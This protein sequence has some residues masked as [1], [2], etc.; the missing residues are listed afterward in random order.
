MSDDVFDL[1]GADVNTT[2]EE[3]FYQ[4]LISDKHPK[5]YNCEYWLKHQ[6]YIYEHVSEHYLLTKP[7]GTAR[8][9]VSKQEL[10]RVLLVYYFYMHYLPKFERTD[11]RLACDMDKF[12]D[13]VMGNPD[14][15]KYLHPAQNPS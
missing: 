11:G 3:Q 15:K 6:L 9:Q 2:V 13:L 8:V 14:I 7:V 5:L 4:W 1:I 10:I 12:L